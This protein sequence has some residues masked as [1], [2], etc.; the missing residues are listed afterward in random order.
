MKLKT[1]EI[2]N[3]GGLENLVINFN[4]QMNIICGPNGIGKTTILECIAHCFAIGQN[5]I[6]KKKANT[7]K[8][9][10][11]ISIDQNGVYSKSL[12]SVADFEPNT[13]S[14]VSGL[15]SLSKYI[16]PLKTNRLFDYQP[17]AAVS[18]DPNK[19]ANRYWNNAKDGIPLDNTK[20]WFVNRHLY[21]KHEDSLT[22][23]QKANLDTAKKC[24]S[25]LSDNI[26][27][28]R[29]KASD[30]EIMVLTPTGEIYYEYLSSGFKSC[31]S[32]LFGIIK[33]IEFR[34]S[35]DESLAS[36]F[37]GVVLIDEIDLHLHPEWQ[38]TV[39]KVLVEIF[40]NAQFIATTH[41]PHVIQAA[42]PKQIIALEFEDGKTTVREVPDS[43]YGFK[44]WTIDEVLT[45]VMGMTDTRTKLFLSLMENFGKAI[46]EEDQNAANT[47][48]LELDRLLHPENTTRKLLKI[49]L[50]S[51]S[52]NKNDKA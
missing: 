43:K 39:Q 1:I 7:E 38:S 52:G 33:E 30:N 16:F 4:P 42:D 14:S 46:D 32:I 17:L 44:G 10:V 27:F 20:N 2:D 40:P 22:K 36:N 45:D 8:S 13:N 51:I 49:Q 3:V 9:A 12:I 28:N 15:H 41:S 24:F 23:Q 18:K 31:L 5:S 29:V 50:A 26:K 21:S 25:A 6:L 48:F 19:D 47:I 11:S 34:F 35:D 37:S